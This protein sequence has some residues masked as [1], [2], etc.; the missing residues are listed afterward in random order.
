MKFVSMAAEF[1][2]RINRFN[3]GCMIDEVKRLGGK[4]N[5]RENT[6]P[7]Q[8][9]LNFPDGSIFVAE[10]HHVKNMSYFHGHTE[11][12][13]SSMKDLGDEEIP[14]EVRGI[15]KPLKDTMDK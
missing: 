8:V 5:Y 11:G 6:L 7:D 1:L 10:C 14:E 13:G 12:T 9:T 4:I 2:A 3:I 15:Y